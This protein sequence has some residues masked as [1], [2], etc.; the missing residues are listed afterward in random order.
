MTHPSVVGQLHG[1]HELASQLLSSIPPEEAHRQYHAELGSPAWHFAHGVYVETYW[2]RQFLCGDDD[3]TRRVEH[4]FTPGAL[5]LSEQCAAL[6]PV[7]HLL[8]WAA[9]IRD[10]HLMRLANPGQ[11]PAHPLLE[12]GRLALF[13][14][15]EQAMDYEHMLMALSQRMLRRDHDHLVSRPLLPAMPTADLSE[16]NQ[17]H[18]RIGARDDPAA[19]DN[20]LPPQAVEL[21]SCRIARHP[22]NN[23][24]YLAFMQAGGYQNPDYWTADGWRYVQSRNLRHPEYWCEDDRGEWFGVGVNGASDLPAEEPVLGISRHEAL[25]CAN[26]IASLGG[27]LSGAVLQHEYQWEVAAR[28]R[29]LASQ[30]RVQEWC[31]NDFHPYPEYQPFP[32]GRVSQGHF[33]RGRASLRGASL[34]S[35]PV[36]RRASR[37]DHRDPGQRFAFTGMRLVFPPADDSGS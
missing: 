21:S 36:L 17:G 20:E 30:G 10:E 34:H 28:T 12:N 35:Q 2:L 7:D 31:A 24:Q 5:S 29:L 32:D 14:A 23:A 8:N 16:L 37:R 19:Y 11:L 27:A 22:L 25:A 6:P 1:L 33:E 26:W 3:L 18:Y 9:E 15:Q 4:L 13:L